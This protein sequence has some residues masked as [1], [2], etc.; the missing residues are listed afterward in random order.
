[1]TGLMLKNKHIH[2][3]IVSGI[4]M[5]LVGTVAMLTV[6][7]KSLTAQVNCVGLPYGTEGCPLKDDLDIPDGDQEAPPNC[8]DG[9]LNPDE[10]CDAGRFN[11]LSRCSKKCKVLYCGDGD[12]S[13]HIGEECEPL[14]QEI[15]VIDS[16][17][18]QMTVEVQYLN[19]IC[20]TVCDVPVCT[21]SACDGGCVYEFLDE[22]IEGGD[23]SGGDG[24]HPAAPPAPSGDGGNP[25][26]ASPPPAASTQPAVC[27]NG[28]LESPEECDDGNR[29]NYDECPNDCRH[30]VC[31]DGVREGIEQCDDG[32][33]INN[34]ECPTNC[35][36]PF[37]G[38]GIREGREECDDGNR[39][40]L[41]SC[42]NDFE[43][44]VCGDSDREGREQC[45]DGNLI[46]DDGCTNKCKLVRCGDGIIQSGEECDDGNKINTDACSNE[47]R[48]AICGD[49]IVHKGDECDDG[50][51]IN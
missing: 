11:G 48:R 10:E 49:G 43:N 51:K 5:V 39:N 50:N 25:P 37:C 13:P 9:V 21:D 29:N 35:M 40:D 15:Y 6:E 17:T 8:G 19:E 18:G 44:A 1:M 45:D 36:L 26:P 32:N 23:D 22:C 3:G 4:S 24:K 27:G 30:S 12:I 41:D 38:N 2:V 42:P 28:L 33:H 7:Q 46:D 20:G 16:L 47:C 34:D 14:T 31:G